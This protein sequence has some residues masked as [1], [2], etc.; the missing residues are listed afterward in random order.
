MP[1]IEIRADIGGSDGYPHTFIDIY[2]PTAPKN[3]GDLVLHMD[4]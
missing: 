4:D 2:N 3:H 1:Q